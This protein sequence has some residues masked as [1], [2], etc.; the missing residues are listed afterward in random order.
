MIKKRKWDSDFFGK[1]IGELEP[2]SE[3]FRHIEFYLRKAREEK[4]QYILCRLK[5]M[6]TGHIR[7]LESLGFYLTDIGVTWAIQSKTYTVMVSP[8]NTVDIRIATPEDIRPLKKIA[9]T[10]FRTSRFYHDPFFSKSE[11]KN[12]YQTWIENSITGSAADIVFCISGTGFITCKKKNKSTGQIP[13]IGIKKDFQ[14]KGMGKA[15]IITALQWFSKQ[16]IKSITVRTQFYNIGAIN[17]YRK[18][19][20]SIK[21]YDIIFAKIL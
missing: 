2:D 18:L 16:Q 3:S 1:K 4:F 9:G 15:L 5:A 13:L 19:G 21:E 11:A 14:G 12:L 10:L 8:N 20:F 17:F 7:V 6:D